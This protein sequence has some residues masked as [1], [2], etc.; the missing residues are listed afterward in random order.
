MSFIE[1]LEPSQ[2]SRYSVSE[3]LRRSDQIVR[4]LPAEFPAH[5]RDLWFDW[6]APILADRRM[7]SLLKSDEETRV[8]GFPGWRRSVT[9]GDFSG[10]LLLTNGE[11]VMGVVWSENCCLFLTAL[12]SDEQGCQLTLLREVP[13]LSFDR[14]TQDDFTI[15]DGLT[16][17]LSPTPVVSAL[18]TVETEAHSSSIEVLLAYGKDA[19]HAIHDESESLGMGVD[20]LTRHRLLTQECT[21]WTFLNTEIPVEVRTRFMEIEAPNESDRLS[22]TQV[23]EDLAHGEKGRY[24]RVHQCRQ[25]ADVVALVGR[26]NEVGHTV[27]PGTGRDGYCVIGHHASWKH[28]GLAHELGHILHATHWP[29]YGNGYG[30]K[31]AGG[32]CYD[33]KGASWKTVMGSYGDGA[34]CGGRT[35]PLWSS[36]RQVVGRPHGSLTQ[37]NA[38]AIEAY[39]D[40]VSRIGDSL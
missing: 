29:G 21:N 1:F 23:A 27:V 4:I 18:R 3:S 13:E 39:R 8:A 33:A 19:I 25:R 12:G 35:I 22:A 5:D 38:A 11:A 30:H 6:R 28:F 40:E 24:Q 2:V 7:N 31:V 16:R 20:A 36:Q 34:E 32:Y 14:Q 10:A 9:R 37:D 15:L 26:F 17:S